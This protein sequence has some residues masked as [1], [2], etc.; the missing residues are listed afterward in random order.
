ME[1]WQG[2]DWEA[3]AAPGQRAAWREHVQQETCTSIVNL[4]PLIE[5]L[6]GDFSICLGRRRA[7]AAWRRLE[8]GELVG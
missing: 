8:Q 1:R 2:A 6:E 7:R 4:E 3:G 5:S